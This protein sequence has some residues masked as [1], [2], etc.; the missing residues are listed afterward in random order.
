MVKDK[1]SILA[2]FLVV[3][4][5][6]I[7]VCTG[8]YAMHYKNP[9]PFIINLCTFISAFLFVFSFWFMVVAKRVRREQDE[10]PTSG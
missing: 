8:E 5:G 4:S 7:I 6:L 9:D 10:D 3:I 1:L 2:L